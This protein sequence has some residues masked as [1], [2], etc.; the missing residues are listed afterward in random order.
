M[1]SELA[2]S[3]RAGKVGV[4][5]LVHQAIARITDLDGRLNAVV[6][7]RAE[8]AVADAR[9]LDISL[10]RRHRAHS[11]PLAGLPLLV[12]D[13]EDVSGMR[14]TCGS[15]VLAEAAPSNEDGVVVARLRAAGAI[16]VGK[17]NVPEFAFE[18][19]TTNR[20]FGATRN[21]W[22]LDWSPG[23]SSGGSAA[24]LAAGLAPVVTGTDAGGS[25][26]VPASYS[27]LVGLKPTNGLVRRDRILTWLEFQT[28]GVL[29]SSV[30]DAGL[31]LKL[32][33]TVGPIPDQPPLNSPTPRLRLPRRVLAARRMVD[34]GPLPKAID[35]AFAAV[36]ERLENDVGMH[37]EL[38]NT[39]FL[40]REPNADDDWF[41]ISQV[42]QAWALG[43]ETI[44]QRAELFDPV[45]LEQLQYGLKVDAQTYVAARARCFAYAQELDRLLDENDLLLTPTMAVEG[46]L[47]DGRLPGSEKPG[48][49]PEACNTMAPNM[50]GHPA[51]SLPAGLLPNGLPFG[52][53]MVAPRFREDL[54]LSMGRLWERHSPWPHV[55]PGY[56][57]F[58]RPA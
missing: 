30:S 9:A 53:Q 46:Y 35:R 31:L 38:L 14:T 48:S 40:P 41:T 7:I 26:R 36:L 15:L 5:E 6:S 25:I 13:T 16:V 37:V 55:A 20:L 4:E 10:R 3:V 32:M 27:G 52:I 57:P 17:T 18:A 58:S 33:T 47:C 23:G 54:L 56:E 28:A 42:E 39:A 21:P 50:T 12:K 45:F 2:A 19:Y 51:L 43:R 11:L 49:P 34:W 22:S 24:A 44:E 29:A 1:L 8:E